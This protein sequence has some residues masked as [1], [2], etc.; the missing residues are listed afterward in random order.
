M[1]DIIVFNK[2]RLELTAKYSN[3]PI[4]DINSLH[5]SINFSTG[6]YNF[7]GDAFDA[8]MDWADFVKIIQTLDRNELFNGWID[9]DKNDGI[10]GIHIEEYYKDNQ[11]Y[12]HLQNHT[13][14]GRYVFRDCDIDAE[15]FDEMLYAG[16]KYMDEE[17]APER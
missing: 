14:C 12:Y 13:Q 9:F 3:I 1:D 16:S 6:E 7:K 17:Y 5:F 15:L 4:H 11:R 2:N 8:F 10:D